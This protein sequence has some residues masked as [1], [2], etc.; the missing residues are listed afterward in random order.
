LS[1]ETEEL[2]VEKK[3]GV[4]GGQKKKNHQIEHS[5]Q[6]GRAVGAEV[7]AR[8]PGREWNRN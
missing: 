3:K 7:G 2:G 5:D 4:L 6:T 8:S 1:G